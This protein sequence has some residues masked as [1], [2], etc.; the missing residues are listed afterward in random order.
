MPLPPGPYLIEFSFVVGGIEQWS[1]QYFDDVT[2]EEAASTVTIESGATVTGID[3]ALE[4]GLVRTGEVE[5]IPAGS[6]SG[7]VTSKPAGIECGTTCV[8]PFE[9]E[10]TVTLEAEPSPGSVFTGW[11]GK[12]SGTG[13]CE[14]FITG[15]MEVTAT[16][17]PEGESM[18][19]SQ[20]ADSLLPSAAASSSTGGLAI[21]A[22]PQPQGQPAAGPTAKVKPRTCKKS[23]KLRKVGKAERCVK[24]KRRPR[25]AP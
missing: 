17:E 7:V 15:Y 20:P 1:T 23:F 10:K 25:R 9:K 16:F 12:C 5:V 13:P 11:A 18:A 22:D 8:A 4:P 14:V 3:A 6:G 19:L 21:A 24:A 2:E